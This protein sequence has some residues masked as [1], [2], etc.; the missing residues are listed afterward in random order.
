MADISKEIDKDLSLRYGI[1][2]SI[3]EAATI[4][5]FQFIRKVMKEGDFKSIRLM[6]LGLFG[7]KPNRLKHIRENALKNKSDS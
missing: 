7:V 5:P 3:I 6:H 4:A 2:L 1:P